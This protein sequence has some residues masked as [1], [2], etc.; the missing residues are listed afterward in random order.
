MQVIQHMRSE[1][2]G[3]VPQKYEEI[4]TKARM[5]Y[6]N[7]WV[8]NPITEQMM[9]LND[10]PSNVEIDLQFLEEYPQQLI[11]L[12]FNI[13]LIEFFIILK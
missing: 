11:Y 9:R 4:V 6:K 10:I 8:Y 13:T 3:N 1:R 7:H 2:I 5:V 12:F